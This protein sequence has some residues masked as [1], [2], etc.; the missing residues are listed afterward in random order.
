MDRYMQRQSFNLR[1][2]EQGS[3]VVLSA[4]VIITLLTV[5]ALAVDSGNLYR[6]RIA[7]Q[8][9]ADAAALA[10]SSYIVSAGTESVY[11]AAYAAAGISGAAPAAARA[12]ALTNYLA[13]HARSI[14]LSNMATANLPDQP[15]ID[16]GIT[17][18]SQYLWSAAPSADVHRYDVEVTRKIDLF[19]MDL[20]PT[21]LGGVNA[22]RTL[23]ASASVAR[24]VVWSVIFLDFSRSM[25]CPATGPCTCIGAAR[26]PAESCPS[27]GTKFE[28]LMNALQ[29]YVETFDLERDKLIFVPY[30]VRATSFTSTEAIDAVRSYMDDDTTASS[31]IIE[32]IRTNYS[33]SN[34]TNICDALTT[35]LERV[36][37][38]LEA[39]GLTGSERIEYVLFTYGAPTA[40]RYLFEDLKPGG[41]LPEWPPGSGKYDY[42][43]HDLEWVN[44]DNGSTIGPSLL[45]Q[46]GAYTTDSAAFDNSMI[47]PPAPTEAGGPQVVRCTG[48]PSSAPPVGTLDERRAAANL[49]FG[50]C[51]KTMESSVPGLPDV[52]YG[53]N[54]GPYTGGTG[55]SFADFPELHYACPIMLADAMRK[56]P[57]DGIRGRGRFYVIGVGAPAPATA[58]PFQNAEDVESRHD[59]FLARLALDPKRFREIPVY[60]EAGV[61]TPEFDFNGYSPLNDLESS[62]NFPE[63][64]GQYYPEPNAGEL[65]NIFRTL[66]RRVA[67]RYIQ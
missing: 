25:A 20:L 47:T 49:V 40:G 53:G 61:P 55:P 39:E 6:A 45:S 13:P 22:S 66:A 5:V 50:S 63:T 26:D 58:S 32:F 10:T 27:S 56:G 11:N 41:N 30:T 65:R 14:A 57:F 29:A 54:Y 33:P 9:S 38:T 43:F 44:R 52:K 62:P 24:K 42:V 7:L 48:S 2:G 16:R 12:T 36:K 59:V 35:G 67:L 31:A 64:A 4:F 60:Q 51:L 37:A 3:I 34:M 17:V 1:A 19:L 18:T 8:K 21:W 23:S 46:H 28:A 15:D